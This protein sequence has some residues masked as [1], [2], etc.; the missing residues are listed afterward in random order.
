MVR[1]SACKP[2][3]QRICRLPPMLPEFG[4]GLRTKRLSRCALELILLETM[5]AFGMSREP[6]LIFSALQKM[7]QRR[8]L[9]IAA[10]RRPQDIS[11]APRHTIFRLYP[12]TE[13]HQYYF[14]SMVRW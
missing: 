8:T 9:L 3:L 11:R 10:S 13:R 12:L 14:I 4:W 1:I 7:A 5:R 6:I 2:T